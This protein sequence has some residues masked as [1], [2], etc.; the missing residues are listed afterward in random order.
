MQYAQSFFCHYTPHV[1]GTMH[2]TI[3]GHGSKT[4]DGP[5][6]LHNHDEQAGFC[7]A[8]G[9]G[10]DK[11]HVTRQIHKKCFLLSFC[12]P[13]AVMTFGGREQILH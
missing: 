2:I 3:K 10:M 9:M 5:A 13:S 4:W 12:M 11:Q 6:I 7:T 8:L 1:C